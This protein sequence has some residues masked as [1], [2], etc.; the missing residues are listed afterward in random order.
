MSRD[1]QSVQEEIDKLTHKLSQMQKEYY[2][3]GLPSHSDIEYDRMFDRLAQLEKQYPQYKRP[4]SP[5]Q[6]VGSDLTAELPEVEHTV[7]VLSLNKSYT[8][9]GVL[10]WMER[11]IK[12]T[13][14]Q[15]VFTA[16]EKI[17][18]VSIVLYYQDGFLQQAVTRGNG[19]VGND[20]TA[21]ART[22]K[23]IPLRLNEP[24]SI[25]VRGEIFLPKEAFA[26]HN[27]ELGTEFANPR[28]LAAGTMRRVKSRDAAAVPLEIFV[29]EG[30]VEAEY[31]D[32]PNSHTAMLKLLRE[33]GFKVNERFEVCSTQQKLHDFIEKEEQDRLSLPY[34]IDGLVIKVDQLDVRE[35][36]GYTGHHPRW[37][38]AYKFV[39]PQAE[40]FV[41]SIDVQ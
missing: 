32:P 10:V 39:A 34:E 29:Y 19:F 13:S 15:L 16:E 28:N 20:V 22:I 37:A 38:I 18:G 21:N 1:N 14:K 26:T 9:E 7:P 30:Y 24:I 12:K 6:R 27:K 36:V 31:S 17:D 41:E 11:L 4:D 35:Q 3:Q 23:S 8:A 25:A 5:T 2:I 33:L 40:T